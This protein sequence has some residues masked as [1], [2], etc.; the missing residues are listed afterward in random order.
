MSETDDVPRTEAEWREVLTDEEYEKRREVL[1]RDVE[2]EFLVD[3]DP[4]TTE[5]LKGYVLQG[6]HYL[7]TGESFCDDEGCR[8]A[9]PH[10]QP[11]VVETVRLE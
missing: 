6:V 3:D 10:R 11:G 5:A 2:G 8:L 7:A 9:N 1:E 4:R